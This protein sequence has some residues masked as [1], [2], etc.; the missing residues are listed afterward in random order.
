MHIGPHRLTVRT[1]DFHSC[2][3]SSILRGAATLRERKPSRFSLAGSLS[4]K[5]R[6]QSGEAGLRRLFD[7]KAGS[8]FVTQQHGSPID[9][10]H[11]QANE[12]VLSAP[13]GSYVATMTPVSETFDATILKF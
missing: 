10:R 12:P 3:R 2:N 6:L 5:V 4:G 9:L 11:H 8:Q 7:E 1:Q 13:A